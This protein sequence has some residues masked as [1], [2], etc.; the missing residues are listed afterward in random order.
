MQVILGW[1]EAKERSDTKVF[2]AKGQPQCRRKAINVGLPGAVGMLSWGVEGALEPIP[3]RG[4]L[5]REGG[6]AHEESS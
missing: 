3:G 4:A 2:S 6:K 1:E 5:G